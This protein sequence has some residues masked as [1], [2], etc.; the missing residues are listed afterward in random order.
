MKNA[1]LKSSAPA[2]ASRLKGTPDC[3]RQERLLAAPPQPGASTL[4]HT[5]SPLDF[6]FSFWN[7]THIPNMSGSATASD[8]LELSPLDLI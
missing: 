6:I 3:K 1:Q 4:V 5:R 2:A 8:S 7:P